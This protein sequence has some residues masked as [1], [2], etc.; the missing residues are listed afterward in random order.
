MIKSIIKSVLSS[1]FL[2]PFKKNNRFVI[3]YHDISN[4]DSKQYSK[5]YSTPIDTFKAHLDFFSKHFEIVSLETITQESLP[6]GKNYLAI[7][8][9]DGFQSVKDVAHP[10]L[11]ER[12]I[13]YTLFLNQEA[14]EKNQLWVS[15][16]ELDPNNK[17]YKDQLFNIGLG[18][19]FNKDEFE[20]DPVLMLLYLGKFSNEFYKASTQEK[21]VNA[22]RL[23]LN[24][25]DIEFLKSEEVHL[26]NHSKNHFNLKNSNTE[27]MKDQIIGN[28]EFLKNEL[29]IH[30]DHFAIPFGKK[31][32]YNE[33]V[34]ETLQG[35]NYIH[36]YTTNPIGFKTPTF[37]IPRIVLTEES[38]AEVMF[39]FNRSLIMNIDL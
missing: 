15:N 33:A 36:A 14:I 30:S 35:V 2:L 12:N 22:E 10:I 11:K 1:N 21:H 39:Y 6:E 20:Q 4:P 19:D 9:D 8:F 13:P 23:Y 7:T 24:K 18:K 37:Y 28:H 17:D 32:H 5:H 34:K 25:E 26:G 3:C 16:I 29:N 27:I 38:N 31:E